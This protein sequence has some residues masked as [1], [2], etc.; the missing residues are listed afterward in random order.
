VRQHHVATQKGSRGRATAYFARRG[1]RI[2][3]RRSHPEAPAG[4]EYAEVDYFSPKI[5]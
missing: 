5:G 2:L 1:R 4:A 3:L